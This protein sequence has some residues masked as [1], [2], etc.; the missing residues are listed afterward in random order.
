MLVN[1]YS[2]LYDNEFHIVEDRFTIATTYI[3]TWYLIDFLS[4][5]PL[6]Q[7]LRSNENVNDL[8]RLARLVKMYKLIKM[9]AAQSAQDREG[10]R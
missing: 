6:D 7:I 3:K 1:F 10:V 9:E 2:D 5:Y 4:I 8:A